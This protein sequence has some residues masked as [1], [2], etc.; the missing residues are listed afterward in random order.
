[1]PKYNIDW[2]GLYPDGFLSYYGTRR[3]PRKLHTRMAVLAKLKETSI[4]KM[5]V[6]A[7]EIGI[8]DIEA[9]VY[10]PEVKDGNRPDGA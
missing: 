7:L 1:M 5:L 6:D 9:E 8:A 4:E 2:E 3:M 10:M